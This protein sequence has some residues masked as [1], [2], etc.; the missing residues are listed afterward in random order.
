MFTGENMYVV[1][2][3]LSEVLEM[4]CRLPATLFHPVNEEPSTPEAARF[5]TA[6]CVTVVGDTVL[7][8]HPACL[9]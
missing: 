6:S 9:T 4:F 3:F 8:I 5:Q 7:F 1:F 2:Y